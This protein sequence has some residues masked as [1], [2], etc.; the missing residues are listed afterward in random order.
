MRLTTQKIRYSQQL[1]RKKTRWV[2]QNR[3]NNCFVFAVES[4]DHKEFTSVPENMLHNCFLFV[5]RVGITEGRH[6]KTCIDSLYV[7]DVG[8]SRVWITEK[9]VH[10][11]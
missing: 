11:E 6:T 7:T 3:L 10:R 5:A 1:N 9:D 8:W 4:R 2:S